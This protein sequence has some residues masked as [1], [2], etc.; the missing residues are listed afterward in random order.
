MLTMTIR[1]RNGTPVVL[2]VNHDRIT[3]P[4]PD[5][6][7]ARSLFERHSKIRD[8]VLVPESDLTGVTRD[9]VDQD[10]SAGLSRG[11]ERNAHRET[12]R[13]PHVA[14]MGSSGKLC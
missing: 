5:V 14:C 12:N 1:V 6:V 3:T 11:S 13:E 9:F 10:P 8:V 7:V 4:L 2:L